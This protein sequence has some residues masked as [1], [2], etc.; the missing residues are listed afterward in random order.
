MIKA[1]KA[2]FFIVIATLFCINY[3]CHAYALATPETATS[4]GNNLN[5]IEIISNI[6]GNVIVIVGGIIG[7]S[8]IS[9]LRQKQMDATYNYLARLRTRLL[10]F[11]KVFSEYG[12]DIVDR[13]KPSPNRRNVGTGRS[14]IVTTV[15]KQFSLQAHETIDFLKS[16]DGQFPA[17]KG[18]TECFNTF[19]CFLMT[20]EMIQY[21]EYVYFFPDDSN[22]LEEN[23]QIENMS[24]KFYEDN[25]NNI[26]TLIKMVDDLQL[27]QEKKIFS[28]PFFNS[29][30]K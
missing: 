30:K 29:R 7:L 1:K 9:L 10:Y 27:E 6:V 28:I 12:S 18:W 20:C 4:Y 14:A 19:V 13:M 26:K 25:L 24:Q 23:I 16:E 8:Y 22:P 3:C 5:N 11:K 17:Q 2:L 21:N 15:I